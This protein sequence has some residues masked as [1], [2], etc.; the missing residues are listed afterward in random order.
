MLEQGEAAGESVCSSCFCLLLLVTSTLA[1]FL[2]IKKK[3]KKKWFLKVGP[4]YLCN[5][6]DDGIHSLTPV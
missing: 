6:E 2:G 3:K 4:N 5:V 1:T